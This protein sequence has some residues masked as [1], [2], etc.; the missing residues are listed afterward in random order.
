MDEKDNV[1]RVVLRLNDRVDNLEK[2]IQILEHKPDD[3][4]KEEWMD[5]KAVMR[6]LNISPRTLQT[7]RDSGRL[8]PTR[9][10]RKYYYK[11]ADIKALL[12]EN[13]IRY[14]LKQNQGK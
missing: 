14:H 6:A 5:G 12:N 13:Y 1:I 10:I 2:R 8:V 7:L 11:V 9:F 3:L 4:L